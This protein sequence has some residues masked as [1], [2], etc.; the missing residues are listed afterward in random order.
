MMVYR[1]FSL[2]CLGLWVA[3]ALPR[4]VSADPA[5]TPSAPVCPS[6]ARLESVNGV[7]YV[8]VLGAAAPETTS[9]YIELYT[10]KREFVLQLP[11]VDVKT[12]SQL[13]GAPFRSAALDLRNPGDRAFLG[14]SV[15][16][17]PVGAASPCPASVIAV[18]SVSD[19]LSRPV[20]ASG[21]SPDDAAIT[22][23][24]VANRS[25]ATPLLRVLSKSYSCGTPFASARAERVVAPRFPSFI[26]A[27]GTSIVRVDLD[28]H[29][30][31]LRASIFKSSGFSAFDDEAISAATASTYKSAVVACT[32]IPGSYLFRADFQRP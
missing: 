17:S 10:L 32:S 30:H 13:P 16:A 18:P 2:L 9:V 26:G 19:V 29:N 27:S 6:I 15:E 22:S 11:A 21:P 3:L 31:V 5:P 20:P 28:D 1:V 12:A 8:F 4:T 25:V 23:E 14:A 24:L 7:D